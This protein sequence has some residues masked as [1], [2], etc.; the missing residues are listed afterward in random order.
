MEAR[1]PYAVAI[2]IVNNGGRS[3]PRHKKF[4]G[5]TGVLAA[6]VTVALLGGQATAVAAEPEA[7]E[8]GITEETVFDKVATIT[9]TV[10]EGLAVSR[11]T[12]VVNNT[13][14]ATSRSAPWTLTWNSSAHRNETVS[15][16][17]VA[18]T[19]DGAVAARSPQVFAYADNYVSPAYF[20]WFWTGSSNP[21]PV[22]TFTGVVPI[23]FRKFGLDPDLAKIELSAGS[24][25]IGVAEAEP[26]T[27]DWDT[28]G[29]SG[30]AVLSA[31]VWDRLGN[32]GVMESRVWLDHAGP[33]IKTRFDF[34][35]GY[36]RAASAV[37]VVPSDLVGVDKVELLVN[38]KLVSTRSNGGSGGWRMPWDRAAKNGKATMTVRAYDGIGNVG[39]TTRT[40]TVDNTPAVATF[41]PAAGKKVRG[42]IQAGVAS[43]RDTSGLAYL[44]VGLADGPGVLRSKAPWNGWVD[45]RKVADGRRTLTFDVRDK[46]GNQT[47][48]SRQVIVDNTKPTLKATTWP[49]NKAKLKATTS[50]KATARD[51]WGVNRVELLVNGKVAGVDRTSGYAFTL[52]PEKYGKTFTVQLRAYDQAGNVKYSAKRT[53][54]R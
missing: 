53:Y 21:T 43:Y 40:V 20:P 3:L 26:W 27:I 36:V 38:G 7:L 24:R 48:V 47:R 42:S 15:I 51:T 8:S 41:W 16:G 39:T 52:R 35:D 9:P 12:L 45:T 22:N 46:A 11:V 50:I 14:V 23:D 28:K 31:R 13:Y 49:K 29:Y 32:T 37:D 4:W 2:M 17:V 34:A 6:A 1:T 5:R 54:R 33:T 19:A 30:K 25:V 44:S 10:P 18:F